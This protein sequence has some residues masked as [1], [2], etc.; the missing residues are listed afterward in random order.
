MNCSQFQKYVTGLKPQRKS[1]L[2]SGRDPGG[3]RRDQAGIKTDHCAKMMLLLEAS[4]DFTRDPSGI[5]EGS[6]R[7]LVG[8]TSKA[9]A[10]D[11]DCAKA[12]HIPA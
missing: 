5:H 12:F 9:F 3:I 8:S 4:T 7:D 6:N 10:L 1:G 11:S 2:G